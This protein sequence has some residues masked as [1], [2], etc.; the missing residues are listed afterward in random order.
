LHL[1]QFL[2]RPYTPLDNNQHSSYQE[3]VNNH[4]P[5]YSHGQNNLDSKNQ[6]DAH[7]D[8]NHHASQTHLRNSEEVP[9]WGSDNLQSYHASSNLATLSEETKA[10]NDS[11]LT[12]KSLL[13][14]PSRGSEEVERLVG[15]ERSEVIE[16]LGGSEGVERSEKRTK[17]SEMRPL[18]AASG[19]SKMVG[20]LKLNVTS[21]AERNN[22]FRILNQKYCFL[23]DLGLMPSPLPD[24]SS[25]IAALRRPS[26]CDSSGKDA[27]LARNATV[28]CAHKKILVEV[29][30][31]A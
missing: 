28:F 7:T 30:W 29:I 5:Q 23:Q 15:V 4:T 24:H 10:E 12:S 8:H 18:S 14:Y 19:N 31:I 3:S 13:L 11:S 22:C 25:D 16:G 27:P 21:T 6:S 17:Q 9:V 20:L 26:T 2:Q 1:K